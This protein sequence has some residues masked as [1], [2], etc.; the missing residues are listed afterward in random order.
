MFHV[1][2][3]TPVPARTLWLV[4]RWESEACCTNPAK[5][6]T[7]TLSEYGREAYDFLLAEI[8]TVL[9]RRLKIPRQEAIHLIVKPGYSWWPCP[10]IRPGQNTLQMEGN[11]II[12]PL[13]EVVSERS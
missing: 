4:R 5:L 10:A 11:S 1:Q 3:S 7:D 13:E 9:H 6:L 2:D 12:H 8:F